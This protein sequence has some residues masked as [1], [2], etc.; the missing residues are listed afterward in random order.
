MQENTPIIAKVNN[1]EVG[2]VYNERF[3]IK[4]ISKNIITIENEKNKIIFDAVNDDAFQRCFRVDMLPRVIV[5][6]ECQLRSL[7]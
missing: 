7:I 1:K 5:L 2:F 3:I 4:D 6:K